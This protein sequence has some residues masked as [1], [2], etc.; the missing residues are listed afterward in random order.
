MVPAG[1]VLLFALLLAGCAGQWV[2]HHEGPPDRATTDILVKTE[3]TGAD[4]SVNGEY[5]G[6]APLVVPLRYTVETRVYERRR[7]LP[8]PHVETRELPS[9]GREFRFTA[10]APGWAEA[11]QIVIPA[12]EEKREL[13]IVLRPR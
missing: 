2:F 9:Y 5:I 11:E 6:R 4:V 3:P 7:Y 1:A 13:R 10:H 8:W 12:G